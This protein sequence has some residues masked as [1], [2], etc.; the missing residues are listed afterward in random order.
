MR[1][2]FIL[3]PEDAER[4]FQLC[5]E[6]EA[7]KDEERVQILLDL[8]KEGKVLGRGSTDLD[9]EQLGKQLSQYA[10]VM[11]VKKDKK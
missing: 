3:M 7:V 10:N 5:L 6:K 4:F 11:I 8:E 2:F 1:H 9:N